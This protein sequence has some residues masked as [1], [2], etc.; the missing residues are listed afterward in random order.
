MTYAD[1]VI[2]AIQAL[3]GNLMRSVLT[4]LGIVI[5]VA[6][7]ILVVAIGSGAR[8]VVIEQI[9][10]LGSNLLVIDR[11]APPPG[12]YP[13]VALTDLDAEVIGREISG[14]LQAVPVV[15]AAVDV[16][17]G[18]ASW[19][20]S[21][22]GVTEGYFAARDW[23]VAD[24]RTFNPDDETGMA[25]VAILGET[26]A[27][28]LFGDES[29]VGSTIR[30]QH[31]PFTVIGV[32]APKGQTTSGRDQDDIV[33]APLRTA[34][35]RVLGASQGKLDN[36]DTILVKV[37]EN[38]DIGTAQAEIESLLRARHRIAQGRD[39][40]FSIKNLA[41]VMRIKEASASALAWLV[42]A[43]AS[44]SLLVGGIG[45]MNIMLVSVVE[46]TREIGIRMAIGARRR[47]ILTQFLVEAVV[48]SVFG[49]IIGLL[50]G[51]VGAGAIAV[52][53]RWPWIVSAPA[54]AVA[55]GFSI[56]VGM[57]FGFYPARKAAALDPIEAL[58]RE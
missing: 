25:K 56:L 20:T 52:V 24:G 44:I 17:H 18:N 58:R 32:L 30:V 46:R 22:F 42:G 21:L 55:V 11:Q 36:V 53:A 47:D 19:T 13:A 33:I 48:L 35:T 1:A 12:S 49:G 29:P 34:R 10:S 6:A 5:G 16:V 39:D 26:V 23:A 28:T 2:S 37:G 51:T 40:N 45:I 14:V 27:R 3:R 9:R 7:V 38:D 31:I 15:H 43:I 4:M 50:I 54:V 41:D 57:V 8:A